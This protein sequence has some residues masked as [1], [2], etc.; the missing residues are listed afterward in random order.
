[1]SFI[2]V[3]SRDG[4]SCESAK[5]IPL[6]KQGTDV[7]SLNFI[8]FKV[9]VDPKY[10]S[11]AL[12]P[13]SWPKGILFRE[14]EDNKAKSFWMPKPS[15]PSINTTTNFDETPQITAASMETTEC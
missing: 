15:T 11:A 4:L 5:A 10:R 3:A 6:I 14:F 2:Y 12:D 1:M 7:N 9:G 8:S 13:S